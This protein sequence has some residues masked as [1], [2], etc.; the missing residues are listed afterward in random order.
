[1]VSPSDVDYP[2][3]LTKDE[4]QLLVFE[5]HLSARESQILAQFIDGNAERDIAQSLGISA[6]TVH[7]YRERLYK[8]LSVATRGEL[9]AKVFATYVTHRKGTVT[10][11]RESVNTDAVDQRLEKL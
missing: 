4:W 2:S 6:H 3:F 8:K 5:L 7:T 10:E 9:V 11:N 1:M